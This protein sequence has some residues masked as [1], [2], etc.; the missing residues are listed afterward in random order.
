[1]Y[2]DFHS[3]LL[4]RADHGCQTTRESMAML[5]TELAHKIETVVVSPHFYLKQNSIE[6]FL[7]RRKKARARLEEVITERGKPVPQ[8][9]TAAEVQLSTGVS[10][11]EGLDRL[12]IEGTRFILIELPYT[13]WGRAV[14]RSL[15][16]VMEE[17]KLRPI[18][19]HLERFPAENSRDLLRRYA[20]SDLII[21]INGYSLVQM[22]TRRRSLSILRCGMPIVLGSDCHGD[23]DNILDLAKAYRMAEEYLGKETLLAPIARVFG[24]EKN[25]TG[26]T[27]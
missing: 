25:R 1:M 5:Q 26:Q 13:F 17:H 12:C 9:R 11:L 2:V 6:E 19:A 16:Q 21:Q 14:F 24:E 18:I 20:D 22:F 8:I 23:R 7:A 15:D 4:P 27:Q 3:H 10:E